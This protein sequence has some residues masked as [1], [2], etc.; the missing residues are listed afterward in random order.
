MRN[1]EIAGVYDV[2][3]DCEVFIDEPVQATPPGFFDDWS[4]KKIV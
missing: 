2:Q 3:I 4:E 1:N